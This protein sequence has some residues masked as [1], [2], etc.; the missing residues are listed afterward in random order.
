MNRPPMNKFD[1]SHDRKLTL[2]MGW[3]TP[4]LCQEVLPGDKWRV[5]PEMMVRLSP[6][7]AP[8]MHHVNVRIHYFFVPYRLVWDDW[9]DFITKGRL[10][11]SAP[12]VPYV[13]INTTNVAAGRFVKNTL[14][15]HLGIPPVD[16]AVVVT[17]PVNISA[18][19]ARVYQLIWNGYFRDQ[20]VSQEVPFSRA[21]GDSNGDLAAGLLA[22]R[23]CG[24]EK[25]YFT[26]SLPF[27]QR[28]PAVSMPVDGGVDLSDIRINDWEKAIGGANPDAGAAAFASSNLQ[29]V[30]GNVVVGKTLDGPAPLENASFL[31]TVFRRAARL[32]EWLERNARAGGRYVE[33]LAS[34]WGVRSSD[35]RLQ[36]PEFLGGIKK[37][38][39]MSEV[40]QTSET[41]TTAQG[42]L[43]GHGISVGGNDGFA[44]RFEEHGIVMG[45]M[46]ILPR[47]TYQQ[48]IPKMFRRFDTFDHYTPEFANI[49]EQEVKVGELW[50]DPEA[51]VGEIDETFGYNPRYAEYKYIPSSVHG[52]MRD[53]YAYWHYGR[54]FSA[55]P[56]LNAD[57]IDADPIDRVFAT[58]GSPDNYIAHVYHDIAALRLMP[59]YDT[60]TI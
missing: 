46:S 41:N 52:D 29:D 9:E 2:S 5:R 40:L 15:D 25:D 38:I 14:F 58:P 24:F 19:P 32:Q 20:N 8:V 44:R 3:L 10:G 57:F 30:G 37:P 16:T 59:Y 4:V 39:A 49:G 1:L 47:T 42:N 6:L 43:A 11:T 27:A 17:Q 21:S 33:Y 18:L 31:I 12:V 51:A 53:V 13:T 56:V 54:I 55:K 50:Y 36:R 22:L 45:L 60:P 48:G 28:G 34:H 23:L 7:I 35:A 26:S